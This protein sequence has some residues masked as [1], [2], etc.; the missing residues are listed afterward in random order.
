MK[1]FINVVREI[2]GVLAGITLFYIFMDAVIVFLITYLLLIIFDLPPMAALIPAIFYFGYSA[3]E[4]TKINKVR[5][6][7]KF[8]PQLNVK[9]RTA[10]DYANVENEVVDDL[11]REVISEMKE[12]AASSFFN[13]RETLEKIAVIIVLCFVIVAITFFGVSFNAFNGKLKE[14]FGALGSGQDSGDKDGQ[15]AQTVGGSAAK[16]DIYGQKSIAKLGDKEIEVEL[17]TSSYEF[18]IREAGEIQEEEEFQSLSPEDVTA[19]ESKNYN[20]KIPVE[21]DKQELIKNYFRKL[22]EG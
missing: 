9:L 10:V 4:E 3:Y 19:V 16:T 21:K 2:K 1:Q 11:H 17:K 12:V 20:E 14:V 13:R 6:V 22:S 7:E 15:I 8:Y 5:I 18:V